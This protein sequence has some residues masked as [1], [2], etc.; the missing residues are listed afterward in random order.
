M[1]AKTMG[2]HHDVDRITRRK[3]RREGCGQA[4]DTTDAKWA[5]I[6]PHVLPP[7]SWRSEMTHARMRRT[8]STPSA[9]GRAHAIDEMETERTRHARLR[10]TNISTTDSAYIA[11]VHRSMLGAIRFAQRRRPL[12]AKPVVVDIR[13]DEAMEI[14][15]RRKYRCAISRL[16][17]WSGSIACY[18]PAIPSLDRM[19]ANRGYARGNIRVVLLGVNGLRGSGTDEDTLRIAQAVTNNGPNAIKE[20]NR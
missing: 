3:Y 18:G 5:I 4:S 6:G 10:A 19:E 8:V 16:A 1:F 13:L 17:F 14:L 12:K 11:Q 2:P 9:R 15:R 7:A 20:R